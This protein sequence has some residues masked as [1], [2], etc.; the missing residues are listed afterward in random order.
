MATQEWLTPAQTAKTLDCS[1]KTMM[2]MLQNNILPVVY[3]GK[4]RKIH[5]DALDLWIKNGGSKPIESS[6]DREPR[7]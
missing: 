4:R 6:S 3:V 1:Y 5:R 7:I 2:R